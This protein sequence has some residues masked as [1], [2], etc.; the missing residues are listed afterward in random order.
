MAGVPMVLEQCGDYCEYEENGN[1]RSSTFSRQRKQ[2]CDRN[3]LKIRLK[4]SAVD[5]HGEGS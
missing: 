1:F 4:A 2:E 3:G 5:F